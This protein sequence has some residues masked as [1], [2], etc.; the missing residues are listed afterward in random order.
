M[1]NKYEARAE[2]HCSLFM[3]TDLLFSNDSETLENCALFL[4][5]N[6]SE[7]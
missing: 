4:K 2:S 7:I 3:K 5:R 6:L 1:S